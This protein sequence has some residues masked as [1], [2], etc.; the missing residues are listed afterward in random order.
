MEEDVQEKN[1]GKVEEPE[2]YDDYVEFT[3]EAEGEETPPVV[4]V[5]KEEAEKPKPWKTP[6]NAEFARQKREREKAE[7]VEKARLDAI[8]QVT[9]G[10]NQY[11]GEKIIDA[12]DVEEYLTM[13]K[14]EAEGKDP[15]TDYPSVMKAK[16][17][18]AEKA[19][20][21]EEANADFIARDTREFMAKYPDVKLADVIAD[22]LFT[23]FANGRVGRVPITEIYR[24]YLSFQQAYEKKT[25]QKTAQQIAN[26]KATTGELKILG[27][28]QMKPIEKMTDK[29]FEKFCRDNGF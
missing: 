8:L 10:V 4:E 6:E 9:N 3:D 11:T 18:E 23:S 22:Q 16:L 12:H 26:A 17:R 20:T 2:I 25:V 1:E 14:L 21:K 28:P 19:R 15:V 27:N 13:R 24:D 7:A 5:K 29:E